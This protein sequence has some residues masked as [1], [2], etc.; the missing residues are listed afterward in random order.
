MAAPMMPRPAAA[1]VSPTFPLSSRC[2]LEHLPVVH[3]QGPR[4]RDPDGRGRSS[5]E[6]GPLRPYTRADDQL[7]C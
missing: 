6:G 4:A 2:H 3:S 5:A 1:R 7:G